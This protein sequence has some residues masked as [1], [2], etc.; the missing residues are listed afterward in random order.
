MSL[1]AGGQVG[2]DGRTRF[3]RDAEAKIKLQVLWECIFR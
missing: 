2:L 3:Q 1:K